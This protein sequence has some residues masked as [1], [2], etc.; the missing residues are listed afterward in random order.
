MIS[1]NILVAS[2]V[3]LQGFGYDLVLKIL[4]LPFLFSPNHKLTKI[5]HTY[6]IIFLHIFIYYCFI[7]YQMQNKI[8]LKYSLNTKIP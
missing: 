3:A 5:E 4:S 1:K 7:F 6:Y 8:I 2:N